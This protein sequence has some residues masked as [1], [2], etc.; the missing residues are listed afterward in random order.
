MERKDLIGLIVILLLLGGGFAFVISNPSWGVGLGILKE[1]PP[2]EESLHTA[3]RCIV[4]NGIT[5][6]TKEYPSDPK[7]RPVQ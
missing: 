7:G 2:A 4:Q 3:R 1:E 6:C 5:Y